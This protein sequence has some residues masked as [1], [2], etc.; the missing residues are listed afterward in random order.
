MENIAK[1]PN[2]SGKR[3]PIIVLGGPLLP[4][5]T[6]IITAMVLCVLTF[7]GV[8]L[9]VRASQ[10][11]ALDP[12]G[13]V[14][15]VTFNQDHAV[16]VPWD[17]F[18]FDIDMVQPLAR[19]GGAFLGDVNGD[20]VLDLLLADF[21][22]ARLLFP[23]IAGDPRRFGHGVYLQETTSDPTIDP[24]RSP[25][26]GGDWVQG[27]VGDIDGEGKSEIII[28]NVLYRNVG[29]H[30]KP[31]LHN[32]YL[33]DKGSWDPAAALGDLNGDGK[34]DVVVTYN[35]GGGSWVYWN[36]STPGHFRF[37]PQRLTNWP[38]GS[39][40]HNRLTV[41]DLNGDG[42]LDLAGR[43]GIYVNTGTVT[44][45]VFDFRNPE[46]WTVTGGGPSWR[47]SSDMGLNVFLADG[48]GDGLLD[49]YVSSLSSTVWQVLFYRNTG[50][51]SSP[52]FQ[53]AGPV[54]VSSTP[55]KV[56]YRGDTEPSFSPK[57]AF[58]SAGDIDQNGLQEILLSTSGGQSFGA[59]TIL[60]NFP[61]ERGAPAAHRLSYQ[62]LYTYPP[63]S[64]VVS[65]CYRE[66]ALCQ[67]PN[68]FS[69][70][71]DL[72]NDG[73]PDAL[74]TNEYDY[75]LYRS[76]RV[77]V[78]PFTLSDSFF[79]PG[80]PIKTLSG[81]GARGMGVT[82]VD[83]DLDGRLDLVVGTENGQLRYYRNITTSG[84]IKLADPVFLTDAAGSRID[85]GTEAWPTA[86]DL[87]GDG[88][89][90]FLVANEDGKIR[91]VFAAPPGSPPRT[92]SLGSFLGTPEQTPVDVTHVV[93][94]GTIAPSLTTLD[95]DGDGLSDVVMGTADGE[96]WLLKNLGTQSTPHF[97][98]QPL[99]VA[100]TSAAYME[101]LDAR[102]VRLYFA[103]PTVSGD[104]VLTYHG[105]PTP[106]A[107]ISGRVVIK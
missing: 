10:N 101:L 62:D 32:A 60:W 24:F 72:T 34:L 80:A 69:A 105:V 70:W 96:L 18:R 22:G 103:L 38:V 53:Y 48:D 43:A 12:W 41:G 42:L 16:I 75:K 64:K 100:R 14:V 98:L 102:R 59:P 17:R 76:N 77:G 15:D 67:P 106:G 7:P 54:V 107:P 97:R 13:R 89:V 47:I 4:T 37:I 61:T 35:Y 99:T 44:V 104:T 45:P 57:R 84:V 58:A 91:Q 56:S 71:T 85:V 23:G 19:D 2:L 21:E 8:A 49:A 65:P 3:L 11:L 36:S 81:A 83:V 73:L 39:A 86:I 27:A 30:T 6:Q 50:T 93:G 74:V 29:T 33:F 20:D 82:V 90:D 52:V 55:V 94:G 92:Y 78:W 66:D 51:P 31:K 68:L 28:G 79:Y 25:L 1:H 5:L 9:A 87:N 88:H 46:P 40:P 63:L 26:G 95:V